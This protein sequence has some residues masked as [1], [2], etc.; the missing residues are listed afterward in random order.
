MAKGDPVQAAVEKWHAEGILD[1]HQYDVLRARAAEDAQARNRSLASLFM[2]GAG[3]VL[4]VIAFVVLAMIF[5]DDLSEGARALI[6]WLVTGGVLALGLVAH[7][8]RMGE[9]IAPWLLLASMPVAMIAS[10]LTRYW[11]GADMAPNEVA[12]HPLV[13]STV[14]FVGVLIVGLGALMA[15]RAPIVP[16]GALAMLFLYGPFTGAILDVDEPDPIVWALNGLALVLIFGMGAWLAIERDDDPRKLAPG[17]R[18]GALWVG[19]IAA[20]PLVPITWFELLDYSSDWG[21]IIIYAL[22]AA[23]AIAY[24]MWLERSGTLVLGSIVLIGDAW[25]FGITQGEQVGTFLALLFSAVMLFWLG[26]RLG[27]GPLK[28]KARPDTR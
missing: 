10:A 17:T 7:R 20:V 23:G 13:V 27:I 21:P 2:L 1:E 15:R 24:G 25:Y 3:A 26:S 18:E 12:D 28:R 9:K 4:L 5:W 6:L 19:Y 16:V 14:L 8:D 11:V 22:L